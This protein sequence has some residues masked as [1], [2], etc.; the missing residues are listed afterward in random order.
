MRLN[1]SVFELIFAQI[2]IKKRP[3]ALI[4][5]ANAFLILWLSNFS[6]C[7]KF[8]A[9]QGAKKSNEMITLTTRSSV[10]IAMKVLG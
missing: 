7:Q 2:P 10:E 4:K 9:S 6:R 1:S 8:G 5:M 3:G